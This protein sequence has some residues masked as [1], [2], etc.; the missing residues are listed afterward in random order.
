MNKHVVRDL[1]MAYHDAFGSFQ[2]SAF[3]V[4]NVALTNWRFLYDLGITACRYNGRFGFSC[5][6]RLP[7]SVGRYRP[8]LDPDEPTVLT[9]YVPL[10]YPG[11]PVRAQCMRGRMDLLTTSYADYESLMVGQLLE[12]FGTSFDPKR[13]VAGIILNR[14]GHAYVVPE[15]GFF[16][17]RDGEPAA[18]DV[19]RE[20]HGRIR[21]RSLG[22]AG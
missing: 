11:L 6:I 8:P 12:L 19:I 10:I 3:L 4:A 7:M 22:A 17:G 9:F 21:L 18:R 20:P 13:D 1:P 2:H 5:N 15:P 14:W 16:F